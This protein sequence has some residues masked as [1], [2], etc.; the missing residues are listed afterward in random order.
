MSEMFTREPA[1]TVT[2]ENHEK[3]EYDGIYY[4]YNPERFDK[5]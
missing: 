3:N 2:I 5:P 4:Y 1:F